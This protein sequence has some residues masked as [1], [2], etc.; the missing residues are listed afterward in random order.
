MARAAI[1]KPDFIIAD[2]PTGELD[3]F[4]AHEILKLL[5]ASIKNQNITLLIS[6][7]DSLVDEYAD[8]IFNLS[9]GKLQP[10]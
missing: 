6:T 1:N 9:D 2:E 8:K 4:T 3:T 7:H 10:L 5:K